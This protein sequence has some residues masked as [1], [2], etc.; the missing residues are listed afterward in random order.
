MVNGQINYVLAAILNGRM[1]QSFISVLHA[2]YD[3]RYS[4]VRNA[5]SRCRRY[6]ECTLGFSSKNLQLKGKK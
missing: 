6:S 5:A 3:N 2:M 1:M 4:G